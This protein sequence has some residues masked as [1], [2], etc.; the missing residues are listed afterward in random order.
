MP[1]LICLL[2]VPVILAGY[3]IYFDSTAQANEELAK[4]GKG[5]IFRKD[6]PE[7]ASVSPIRPLIDRVEDIILIG[8]IDLFG[9]YSKVPGGK[10]IW[11]LRYI[12]SISP[13]IKFSDRTYLIPLYNSSFKK[14]RQIIS[15]E[16]G[17]R[18]YSHTQS[19][20]LSLALKRIHTPRLSSR[21]NLFVGWNLNKETADESWGEGLY[22]Y[23]DRGFEVDL[24]YTTQETE[25]RV[26]MLNF[27]LQYYRRD[28]PNFKSLIS[29]ASPTA[30]EVNEKN[31]D[32]YRATVGYELT[33]AQDLTFGAQYSA[34]LKNFCDKKVIDSGGILQDEE[35]EDNV[36]TINLNMRYAPSEKFTLGLDSE[37]VI[38][39]SNQNFHDSRDTVPLT[40]DVFTPDYFDYLSYELGPSLTYIHKLKKGG[41]VRFKFDYSFL[42][43]DYPGRK[44]QEQDDTYTDDDQTD[45]VHRFSATVSYPLTKRLR[46]IFLYEYSI[47][48]S[49]MEYERYYRYDYDIYHILTGISF[50]F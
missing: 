49:N 44:A 50:G 19:H 42:V 15:V 40:D 45:L 23:R 35:R 28:Y 27:G 3:L 25:D 47:N 26:G 32:G 6:I 38:N 17:A 8:N 13:V 1:K 20:N 11:G 14:E 30:P 39:Q 46:W 34:L 21:S 4:D 43:R 24:Q 12:G 29:L 37:L 5:F 31:Y 10:D 33:R 41:D 18:I 16:E 9:A 48:R 36:H 2:A 22:D 7:V